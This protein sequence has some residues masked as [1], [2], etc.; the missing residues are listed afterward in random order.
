[1][2]VSTNTNGVDVGSKL[3]APEPRGG[4]VGQRVTIRSA[5]PSV[6][7]TIV[8]FDD[9]PVIELA[10]ALQ[11]GAPKID[12]FDVSSLFA[13]LLG[14]AAKRLIRLSAGSEPSPGR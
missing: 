1:M 3:R 14:R 13:D 6:P 10:L 11:F 12:V 2:F 4:S 8:D 9:P 5:V 7:K